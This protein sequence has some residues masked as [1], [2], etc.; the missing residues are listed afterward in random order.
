MSFAGS[1]QMIFFS[2]L[3]CAIRSQGGSNKM[4]ASNFLWLR[5]LNNRSSI[6]LFFFFLISDSYLQLQISQSDCEI[7]SNCGENHISY[8]P[9]LSGRQK[10]AS[11]KSF[12][13]CHY[14][15][16]IRTNQAKWLFANFVQCVQH[17]IVAK[18]L[19]D[20]KVPLWSGLVSALVQTGFF[21]LDHVPIFLQPREV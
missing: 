8:L 14:L 21:Q 6:N 5:F 3:T 19:T 11:R 12:I 2:M 1:I 16:S 10:G 15:K 13:V 4:V 7:S 20:R 9:F 18:H 17:G